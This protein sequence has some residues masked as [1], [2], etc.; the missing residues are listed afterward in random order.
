MASQESTMKDIKILQLKINVIPYCTWHFLEREF[1]KLI[2]NMKKKL[3]SFVNGNS[4]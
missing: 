4:I 2:V 3:I 1:L